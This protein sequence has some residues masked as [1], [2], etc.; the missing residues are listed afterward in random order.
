MGM[1]RELLGTRMASGWAFRL[2]VRHLGAEDSESFARCT[3]ALALTRKGT[4][5]RCQTGVDGRVQREL[6]TDARS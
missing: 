4:A 5:S 6:V 3:R 2:Y 1:G